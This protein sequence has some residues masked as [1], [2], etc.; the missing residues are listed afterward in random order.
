[1]TPAPTK[2]CRQDT[3]A[4][5]RAS[6]PAARIEPRL[7]SS[8]VSPLIRPYWRSGNQRALLF[9]RPTKITDTPRPTRKR[10]QLAVAKSGARPN[11]T[12]PTPATS[13]P[14]VTLMRGPRVSAST[15]EGICRA[16]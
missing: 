2:T 11:S 9:I 4:S 5:S 3:S 15:P 13:P 10:P 8:R 12:E 7:P 6:G 16:V 1:M 14:R